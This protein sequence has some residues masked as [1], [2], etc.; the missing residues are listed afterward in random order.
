MVDPYFTFINAV[1]CK[2]RR[3]SLKKTDIEA[4]RIGDDARTQTEVF[5]SYRLKGM[6]VS[7]T[8][9]RM[10][11]VELWI[12]GVATFFWVATQLAQPILIR[13]LIQSIERGGEEGLFWALGL[14][15]ATLLAGISNQVQLH[16]TF[17]VG[18]RLRSS[19][20][21]LVFRKALRVD[22]PHLTQQ[23]QQ[24]PQSTA[25]SD[26][27]VGDGEKKERSQQKE[28]ETSFQYQASSEQP[29]RRNQT[30]LSA[31]FENIQ[32]GRRR[33]AGGGAGGLRSFFTSAVSFGKGARPKGG[34]DGGPGKRKGKKKEKKKKE[35]SDASVINMLSSDTQ[36]FLVCLPLINQVWAAPFSIFVAAY[37]LIDLLGWPAVLGIVVICSLAPVSYWVAAAMNAQRDEQMKISDLRVRLCGEVLSGARMVKYFHW[38]N[39]FE[40][41]ILELRSLELKR[42]R[43]FTAL[44]AVSVC[45]LIVFPMLGIAVAIAAY[46]AT[47]GKVEAARIFSAVAFFTLVRFPLMQMGSALS[48]L[49]NVLVAL[50]RVRRFLSKPDREAVH[51]PPIE[52][53][54]GG[55]KLQQPEG[56]ENEKED[57]VIR[58]DSCVLSYRQSEKEKE[59][60]SEGQEK[61]RELHEGE[62]RHPQGEGDGGAAGHLMGASP[63]SSPTSVSPHGTVPV[64]KDVSLS[65]RRGEI[66][67]VLGRVGSGKTS[68]LLSILGELHKEGG[69][70]NAEREV[71][72]VP[73]EAWILNDSVRENVLFGTP[74]ETERYVEVLKACQLLRD[75]DQLQDGDM[76]VIG[77][78]GITLSGG[79]KQR[80][81][82]A[83][84]LYSGRQLLLL[85]DCLA[86]LDAHTARAVADALFAPITGLLRRRRATVVLASSQA[87]HCAH[88]D[89]LVALSVEGRLT[90]EAN[91]QE[92]E[93][94]QSGGEGGERA[95]SRGRSGSVGVERQR[96][97]S[98]SVGDVGGERERRAP[99]DR[100][101]QT[102]NRQ[103]ALERVVS[104]AISEVSWDA[105]GR[106]GSLLHGRD[107]SGQSAFPGPSAGECLGGQQPGGC[108]LQTSHFSPPMRQV[109]LSSEHSNTKTLSHGVKRGGLEFSEEETAK[110]LSLRLEEE[111]KRRGKVRRGEGE[112]EIEKSGKSLMTVE[113]VDSEGI[114][115]GLFFRYLNSAGSPFLVFNSL[116]WLVVERCLYLSGD[117][118]LSFWTSE[119]PEGKR[120]PLFLSVYCGI[121]GVNTVAVFLR[122]ICFTIIAVRASRSLFRSLIGCLLRAPQAFY[123]TTPIGRL[124]ARVS[125][126]TEMVDVVLVTK[127]L[128]YIASLFWM[129]SGFAVIAYTLFPWGFL[130][131]VPAFGAYLF[132]FQTARK[133]I[134]QLQTFDSASRSPLQ[135]HVGEALQG[136]VSVRAYGVE[137]RFIKKCERLTDETSKFI[138]A[139]NS[140]NR[141]LG[142]RTEALGAF[143]TFSAAL[144]SWILRDTITGGNVGFVLIWSINL[145]LSLNFFC[146]YGSQFEASMTSVK[147]IFEYSEVPSEMG[148]HRQYLAPSREKGKDK[149]DRD[150]E[151]D[152]DASPEGRGGAEASGEPE[153][154]TQRERPGRPLQSGRNKGGSVSNSADAMASSSNLRPKIPTPEWPCSGDLELRGVNLRYRD[155]L[156]RAL[157]GLTCK[158][159]GGERVAVVGR[160]GAGK[161]SMAVALFRL[162]EP[163]SE[164][165]G[166]GGVL[167]DGEELSC[168]DFSA[169]RGKR[170]G[171]CIVTQD[172]VLFSGVVRSNLDPFGEAEDTEV[173]RALQ[174][175]QM[176]ESLLRMAGVRG[177]GGDSQSPTGQL[178]GEGE[179]EGEQGE[180]D[181]KGEIQIQSA[182]LSLRE[183]SNRENVSNERASGVSVGGILEG[184]SEE[185]GKKTPPLDSSEKEQGQK[186]TIRFENVEVSERENRV[187]LGVAE[188]ALSPSSP[189]VTTLMDID[190][191]LHLPVEEGGLNFSLG[192][193]QLLCLAR[194][195]LRKP[196]VLV[197][198]EA[199]ASVD[200]ATDEKVQAAIRTAPSLKGTSLLT[201]AHRLQTIADYDKVMCLDGGALVEF[202]SPHELL[203]RGGEGAGGED[204]KKVKKGVGAFARLVDA[205][206]PVV[207]ALVRA[208]AR[209]RAATTASTAVPQFASSSSSRPPAG[210]S[211]GLLE[212]SP[213]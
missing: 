189:A 111:G 25:H 126:D 193:R 55:G 130:A 82:L 213:E 156:P 120:L 42:V 67:G 125:F 51:P 102:Q 92:F 212:F 69:S 63:C 41:R 173:W 93:F 148:F 29:L 18:Q 210:M 78:R 66:V 96:K 19:A 197:L 16:F 135:S 70:L 23:Q 43:A 56:K 90:N 21:S 116:F 144:F 8:L 99:P 48:A 201:I 123:D 132:L 110:A 160:T 191:A 58:L 84:A 20:I 31:F 124:V 105:G 136:V 59:S 172:P 207:A 71:A 3:K 168:L 35:E 128:P 10:N 139:F 181:K 61:S 39:Q 40:E 101:R 179:R 47:G 138:F 38:E 188:N 85:D 81:S 79:Q 2:G 143:L 142:A 154:K 97:R 14:G 203:Q 4:L 13:Y 77:E 65:V 202:G 104:S 208:A 114:G 122:S 186:T 98:G 159:R 53:G 15:V 149:A 192:E 140:A 158:I 211:S 52:G 91:A 27:V 113:N 166:G 127:M 24:Q 185:A 11:R 34:W 133:S 129:V 169:V 76:T 119:D 141:W 106:R 68:L 171:M 115:V 54:G 196:R 95:P 9:L 86:A 194:A 5:E 100:E 162:V 46:A 32:R 137:E 36:Q 83:R 178:R 205:S 145:T 134:Q 198:D 103:I 72:L 195:I 12:G 44:F 64:L 153:N 155:G 183:K 28:K 165:T 175:V 87:H 180:G 118:W 200:T 30:F 88:A 37:F 57:L 184:K 177:G 199:T 109:S 62:E 89:R 150:G 6:E 182:R 161:S 151:G 206:G 73:Q 49:V 74:M 17:H 170:G 112:E 94:K 26:S 131:L 152:G 167:L 187:A 147:R 176:A 204:P 146:T 174:E 117:F 22:A 60:E 190:S 7:S 1:V 50:R 107:V 209:Q 163:W 80:F 33:A 157:R 164:V 108:V 45:T 121:Y 75:L